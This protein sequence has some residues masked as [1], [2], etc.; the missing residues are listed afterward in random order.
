MAQKGRFV[1]KRKK[2]TPVAA[3]GG[4]GAAAYPLPSVNK[5]CCRRRGKFLFLPKSCSLGRWGWFSD[6]WSLL[7][8][9]ASLLSLSVSFCP[10]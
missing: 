5:A 6:C 1:E 3:G 8:P 2:N 10:S 9:P 7:L 4:G